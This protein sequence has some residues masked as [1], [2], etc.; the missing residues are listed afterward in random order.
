[1]RGA[2]NPSF[3][4]NDF[5]PR[6]GTRALLPAARHG[7]TS[8]PIQA[9]GDVLV[10]R[11]RRVVRLCVARG[12]F[13]AHCAIH[14]KPS[15]RRSHGQVSWIAKRIEKQTRTTDLIM[16]R[17]MATHSR[18]GV[19][20]HWPTALTAAAAL[21][22]LHSASH[23]AVADVETPGIQA[24]VPAA[25][26]ESSVPDLNLLPTTPLPSV[27]L[28]LTATTTSLNTM[29]PSTA[30]PPKAEDAA[31]LH[32]RKVIWSFTGVCLGLGGL[33]VLLWRAE[34]AYTRH[35][36]RRRGIPTD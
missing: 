35:K 30:I 7:R 12:S 36:L 26:N 4:Q 8:A 10:G 1:M 21:V 15:V 23:A 20:L 17:D 19:H 27:A 34:L 9:E 3:S 18:Q 28:D 25:T 14:R 5:Q 2:F 13:A 11:R 32:R 24:A 22:L 16:N 6:Q 31:T 33:G 29:L